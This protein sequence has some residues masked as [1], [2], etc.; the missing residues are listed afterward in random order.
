MNPATT[1]RRIMW[2][3]MSST[4]SSVG[5]EVG[6]R[7]LRIER[8]HCPHC[9]RNVSLKT[10]KMHKRL[11]YDDE[12]DKWL[13]SGGSCDSRKSS[14]ESE[15]ECDSI[16]FYSFPEPQQDESKSYV[17]CVCERR[18]SHLRVVGKGEE[19][20]LDYNTM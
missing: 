9:S 19:V 15:L 3:R 8:R 4:M 7:M 1:R 20:S 17:Y 16:Q 14:S 13:V 12:C 10:F 2:S 18:L 6:R 11:Y 5:S